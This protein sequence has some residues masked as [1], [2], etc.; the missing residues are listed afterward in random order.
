MSTKRD[1]DLQVPVVEDPKCCGRL[2]RRSLGLKSRGQQKAPRPGQPT[3]GNPE[4]CG[5]VVSLPTSSLDGKWFGAALPKGT[6]MR[7]TVFTVHDESGNIAE[8][9]VQ[10]RN[11]PTHQHGQSADVSIARIT[12]TPSS[13]QAPLGPVHAGAAPAR[14]SRSRVLTLLTA[15]SVPVT[16]LLLDIG[17]A[18]QGVLG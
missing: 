10:I 12:A 1:Y 6:R 5:F 18:I 11:D 8:T 3:R 15:L 7:V 13:H 2:T 16:R 14:G 9:H 4:L 17:T